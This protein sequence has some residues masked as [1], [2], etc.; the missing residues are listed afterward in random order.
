MLILLALGY[1]AGTY[2]DRQHYRSIKFREKK[3]LH[4]PV[5]TFGKTQS[6]PEANEASLFVGSSKVIQQFVG[7]A[8]DRGRAD[9]SHFWG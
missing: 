3:T 6:L 9:D 8:Y 2:F 5:V 4:V 7:A 1:L